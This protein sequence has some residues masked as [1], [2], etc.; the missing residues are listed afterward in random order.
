MKDSLVPW[1]ELVQ[2]LAVGMEADAVGEGTA[3]VDASGSMLLCWSRSSSI[4][5]D[6]AWR[7]V[8]LSGLP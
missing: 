7:V 3:A 1:A 4:A 6:T 2:W 5:G 8:C